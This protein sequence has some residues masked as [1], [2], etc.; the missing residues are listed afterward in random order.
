M[1][2]AEKREHKS[3]AELMFQYYNA[4]KF[5]DRY[6]AFQGLAYLRGAEVDAVF[7][8]ALEDPFWVLR[9]NA[10]QRVNLNKPSVFEKIKSIAL[11][12]KNPQ[13]RAAAFDKLV[14]SEDPEI[15][16]IL[17]HAVEN[18]KS[19]IALG[20][21]LTALHHIDESTAI[22]YAKKLE[23]DESGQ[24]LMAVGEIYAKSGNESHLSFFEGN[25]ENLKSFEAVSFMNSYSAL[26]MKLNPERILELSAQ[27]K[28]MS[29]DSETNLYLKFGAMNALNNLHEYLNSVNL[30]EED[31]Q[32]K[33]WINEIKVKENNGSLK[34]W[35]DNFPSKVRKP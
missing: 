23:N 15:K 18:E 10:I 34:S 11:K 31:E 12:D 13:T 3:N 9:L 21:C 27:L 6:E 8:K 2:L 25:W 33:L 17:K 29:I 30:N 14:H 19:L 5:L 22:A 24:I 28:D 16:N 35:Y 26:I 32:I 20:S 7:E 4:P 1:S